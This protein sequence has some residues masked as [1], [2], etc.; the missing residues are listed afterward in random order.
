MHPDRRIPIRL[1]TTWAGAALGALGGLGA[2][3]VGAPAT[4]AGAAQPSAQ[5]EY[6]AAMKTVGSSGVHFSSTASQGQVTVQVDGDAGA[7]S[8]TE[9]IV[10]KRNGVTERIHAM[11]V[12]STNYFNGNKAALTQVLGFT[13]AQ[14]SKYAGT[15]LSFPT[16]VTGLSGLVS[17]L[18]SSQVR[19]EISLNGPY[20][21]GTAATVNGQSALA[22]K[23]TVRN[24]S[25]TSTPIVL[26]VPAS[27]TPHPLQEVVN[28][29]SGG[30]SSVIHETVSFTHWG[31]QPTAQAPAHSV[32]L[33][34][35]LPQSSGSGSASGQG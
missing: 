12:G 4:S 6:E 14:A 8:G 25:G 32:S 33:L 16:S 31:E 29:G 23:G 5:A 19:T 11:V 3:T 22:I 20:Q 1:A 18:L 24:Q 30:G 13:N 7:S 10:V 17:G 21:Y 35:L 26:Y 28:S 34:K 15:W 2:L 9:T 27:G